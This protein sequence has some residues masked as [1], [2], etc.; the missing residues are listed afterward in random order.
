MAA[1]RTTTKPEAAVE[2][3]PETDQT[4]VVP[5]A[6]EPER[7][8]GRHFIALRRMTYQGREIEKG[9]E[10]VGAAEWPRVDAWVR[11]RYLKEV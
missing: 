4:D 2:P 5:D 1:R 3:P 11:A 6:V 10:V 7:T 9:D 8:P